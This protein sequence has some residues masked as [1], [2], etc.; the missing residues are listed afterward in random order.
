MPAAARWSHTDNH[1][2]GAVGQQ[3][4]VK[5]T[6]PSAYQTASIWPLPLPLVTLPGWVAEPKNVVAFLQSPGKQSYLPLNVLISVLIFSNCGQ[7]GRCNWALMIKLALPVRIPATI[8][9]TIVSTMA[10]SIKVK[11]VLKRCLLFT[12]NV[13]CRYNSVL[14]NSGNS[15]TKWRR[16]VHPT[17]LEPATYAFG[18]Q[19]SIQLS[20][21]CTG[22]LSPS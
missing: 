15:R 6:P 5:I 2:V 7:S 19:Y 21:G 3:P 12:V 4:E 17:G 9:L 16:L 20:Y 10:I 8:S 18:G 13:L 22:R 1:S 14:L 11:P